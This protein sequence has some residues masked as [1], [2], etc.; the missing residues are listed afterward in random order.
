MMR[1]SCIMVVKHSFDQLFGMG[2]KLDDEI[3]A[4]WLLKHSFDQLLGMGGKLDDEILALWLLNT[5][6]HSWETFRVCLTNAAQNGIVTME[7]VKS[8]VLNE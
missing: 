3:L 4:L 7:Y 2:G 8:G 6:T 5:L 1:Y